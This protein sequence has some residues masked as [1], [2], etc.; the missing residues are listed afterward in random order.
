MFYWLKLLSTHLPLALAN[1]LVWGG[2]TCFC[3]YHVVVTGVFPLLPPLG[4]SSNLS[5]LTLF[6]N[7]FSN[8]S[9]ARRELSRLKEAA[10]TKHAI[11]VIWAY[12]LGSKVLDSHIP[13]LHPGVRNHQSIS[14]AYLGAKDY[15]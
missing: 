1:L 2:G 8:A 10:R 12:W 15:H 14:L 7:S 11:A 6:C 13:S 3:I 5:C 9:Q 4:S